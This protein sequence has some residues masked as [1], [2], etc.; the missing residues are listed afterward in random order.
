MRC[1]LALEEIEPDHWVVWAL[2]LPACFSSAPTRTAALANM[3]RCLE[4]YF[5][6]LQS[7]DGSLPAVEEK[8][9][10]EVVETHA[11][12]VS[13]ESPGRVINAFFEA[14]RRPLTYWDVEVALRL[15]RWTRHDLLD[16]LQI[17]QP[18]ELERP[19]EGEIGGSIGGIVRHIAGAE[20]WYL[21]HLGLGLDKKLLPVDVFRALETVRLNTQARLLELIGDGRVVSGRGGELWSARKVVRRALWHERDHTQHIRRLLACRG[22][23]AAA[24]TS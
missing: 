17:T 20:N 12:F 4:E 1:R 8:V 5:A 15:L 3:P 11:A 16:I 2:D 9:A 24:V 19:I 10:V 21:S 7:H 22:G 18:E 14:D 23:S 13:E 6:W